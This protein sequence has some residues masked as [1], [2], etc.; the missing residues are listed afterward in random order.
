MA[1]KKKNMGI[2][3]WT[4]N[5]YGITVNKPTPEQKETARQINAEVAAKKGSKPTKKK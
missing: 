1:G 4:S 3:R 5:G 2:D